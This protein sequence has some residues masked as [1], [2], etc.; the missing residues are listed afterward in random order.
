MQG[1]SNANNCS[2]H[3]DLEC[4]E[5]SKLTPPPPSIPHILLKLRR[6]RRRRRVKKLILTIPKRASA[7][8]TSLLD[9]ANK[10]DDKNLS[11]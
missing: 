4:W 6:R 9:R 11:H 5:L 3:F 1:G 10:C 2:R 7:V 8:A